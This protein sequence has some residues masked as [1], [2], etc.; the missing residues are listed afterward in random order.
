MTTRRGFFGAL[1]G[2]AAMVGAA[3]NAPAAEAPMPMPVTP[4]APTEPLLPDVP[5]E[6]ADNGLY[7]T[8][9]SLVSAY[10]YIQPIVLDAKGRIVK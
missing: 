10:A 6:F 8:A 4:P 2:L 9:G 7:I 3:K 1:A 5:L